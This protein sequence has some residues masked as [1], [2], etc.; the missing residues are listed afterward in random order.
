M[1]RLGVAGQHDGI[2]AVIPRKLKPFYVI[3]LIK[4]EER[5][6]LVHHVFI[7]AFMHAADTET[8]VIDAFL[9]RHNN[10]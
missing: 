4:I 2:A 6:V 3:P 1:L 8:A 10:A 9:I 7:G 5:K